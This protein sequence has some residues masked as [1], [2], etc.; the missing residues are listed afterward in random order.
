MTIHALSYHEI[1]IAVSIYDVPYL[2]TARSIGV[3]HPIVR[4]SVPDVL[5]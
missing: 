1:E 4:D 3:P 2:I 5:T